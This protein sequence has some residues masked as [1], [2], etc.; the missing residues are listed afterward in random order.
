MTCFFCKGQIESGFASFMAEVDN[1]IVVI[2]NVPSQ[3][4]RQCGEASY[5]RAVALRL[6]EMVKHSAR[7]AAEL[8]VASYEELAA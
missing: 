6:E 3:V 1:R 8:S 4:C 7:A 2:K 5:S